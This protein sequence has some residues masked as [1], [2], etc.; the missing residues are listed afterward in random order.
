MSSIH[1]SIGPPLPEPNTQI[2]VV[3]D[4]FT[5]L[6]RRLCLFDNVPRDEE[7]NNKALR[8]LVLRRYPS[9]QDTFDE[10]GFGDK[11][12]DIEDD[13]FDIADKSQLFWEAA[14]GVPAGVAI[15]LLIRFGTIVSPFG[16][17]WNNVIQKFCDTLI[18]HLDSSPALIFEGFLCFGTVLHSYTSI[19][20]PP[21]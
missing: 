15:F 1:V 13:G 5:D 6:E 7:H 12:K 16:F 14:F 8:G 2:P 9:L 11:A 18:L 3:Y 10:I 19:Y 17:L 20:P 21:M 4:D